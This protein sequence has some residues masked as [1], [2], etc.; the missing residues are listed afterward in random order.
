MSTARNP[1]TTPGSLESALSVIVGD[2]HVLT[3]PAG[4]APYLTDWRGNFSGHARAVVRPHSTAQV[5]AILK[6]CAAAETPIVPQGGNTGLC[7]GAT[8]DAAGSAVLLSLSRMNRVR[9]LDIANATLTA[10]AGVTLAAVQ[11][12]ARDAGLL[13]PL[14]LAAEGSCT[15]GGNISTNA[16]GTAVLRYGN[17]RDLVLGVEVVLADGQIWNGL[18]GLRK[19]N[20][21]YDLKQLFIGSEGTLGIV[22]CAV[23]KVF[24]APKSQVTA[25]VALASPA[26]AVQLLGDVRSALGDRLVAFELMS[27]ATVELSH[28]HHSGLPL[29][30]PGHPWY[31][32]LQADDTLVDSSIMTYVEAALLGAIDAGVALD[33]VIAQSVSESRR[34]WMLRENIGEAQRRDGPHIKHDIALPISAIPHFLRDAATELERL[35]PGVRVWAFGHLGDGN[36]HYNVGAPRDADRKAFVADASRVLRLVHDMVAQRGGSISAEHGIG[37]SKRDDLSRYKAPLEI[38]LMRAVKDALDP[39]ALLNP[40]KVL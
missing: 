12:H 9:E 20:T 22:T 21:G 23:L 27:R 33:V 5:A 29:P 16:G 8:P 14:S 30:L 19:D 11:Q 28:E 31:V 40:G 3:D 10:E 2:T 1:L 24:P 37:Q 6:A 26:S 4:M 17:M 34:L 36:L 25:L 32:L 35:T 7:G 38:T 13:F 39:L 18:R 15:I